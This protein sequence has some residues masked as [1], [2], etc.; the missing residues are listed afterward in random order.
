MTPPSTPTTKIETILIALDGSAHSDQAIPLLRWLLKTPGPFRLHLLRVLEPFQPDSAEREELHGKREPHLEHQVEAARAH[1]EE[2]CAQ[3]AP[4]AHEVTAAVLLGH[5]AERI[6]SEAERIDADLVAMV[7]KGRSGP[8][9]WFKG[10][11]TEEVMRQSEV[12]LLVFNPTAAGERE[13]DVPLGGNILFAVDSAGLARAAFEPT[14]A[15]AEA[16]GA[17][18]TIY[19]C[20]PVLVPPLVLSGPLAVPPNPEEGLDAVRDALEPWRIAFALRG[21]DA[22]I[23]I[24]RGQPVNGILQAAEEADLIA[25]TTH[26][27]QGFD[28]FVLGSVTESVMRRATRPLLIARAVSNLTP[29]LEPSSL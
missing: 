9:R 23:K 7:T 1:L 26:G 5:P 11:V 16:L 22:T 21:V 20:R 18:V 8:V 28:R 14:A 3:V 4:N 25:L 2:A 13:P 27:H 17:T 29:T 19:T 12:P 6:L 10:S 15:L 24:D